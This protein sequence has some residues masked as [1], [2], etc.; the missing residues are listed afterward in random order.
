MP[1][2]RCFT[3]S[4]IGPCPDLNKNFFDRPEQVS[5]YW[6]DA[7][8]NGNPNDDSF[9]RVIHQCEPPS[10]LDVIDKI[11]T[12]HRFYDV[13]MAFDERVLREC[14]NAK[15]LTESACSWMSRKTDR[16]DPFGNMRYADGVYHKNPVV[17]AYT[18]CDVTQKKFEVSFLTSSKGALEGHKLRQ[19]IFAQ[20]PEKVGGL[21]TFKH[22]SPPIINDKRTILEP[23]QYSIVPENSRYS[24]YYTEKIVDCFVAKT[25]PIYWGCT[26]IAKHFNPEGILQFSDYSSL[27]STLQRLTPEFYSSRKQA[28]DENFETAL[29]GVH[30]WDLIEDYITEGILKKQSP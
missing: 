18:G 8:P 23:Y 30:Q 15:F 22:R 10:V 2:P 9:L 29:R 27:V 4:S 6:D 28:I 3:S 5:I 26:D 20:L 14:P 16:T 24:G 19:E 12:N 21:R 17:S 7:I 1:H 25:I 11:I 13:I